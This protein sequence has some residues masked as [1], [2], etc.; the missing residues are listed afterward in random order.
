MRNSKTP[1]IWLLDETGSGWDEIVQRM[2]SC[3]SRVIAL[4]GAGSFN[5][6]SNLD[7]DRIFKQYLV[8]LVDNQ[9]LGNRAV[10]I[11]FDGD[12]DVQNLPDIG[13]ICG[14]LLDE[15]GDRVD[16]YAVQKVSWYPY[17]DELSRKKPIHNSKG[18]EY[19]TI[20]F[21]DGAF[22]GDHDHFSQNQKL[23]EYGEYE[24]WYIG[25]CGKISLQQ[26]SD[27]NAKSTKGK[28]TARLFPLRISEAHGEH[29]QQKLDAEIK[30]N[31]QTAK[32]ARL[33]DSLVQRAENP[34]GLLHDSAGKFLYGGAFP[35]LDTIE[36]R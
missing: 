30:T 31:G 18:V 14:R 13:Y 33:A 12:D 3:N 17:S 2:I 22:T 9:L 20:L 6:I 15:F 29:I 25:A 24:Q 28:R 27:Y 10:S 5:G 21:P 26:L 4:R 1:V 11:I 36:V 7:A 19:N 35:N 32:A 34:Y 16:F 23:V 8:P